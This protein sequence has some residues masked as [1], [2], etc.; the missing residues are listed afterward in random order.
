MTQRLWSIL[1]Q[2]GEAVPSE[3]AAPKKY[4]FSNSQTQTP[5]AGNASDTDENPDTDLADFTSDSDTEHEHSEQ[6]SA[7]SSPEYP[8]VPPAFEKD[9][10]T[11][12]TCLTE[13]QDAEDNQQEEE[14]SC[15]SLTGSDVYS[16]IFED[17]ED[18]ANRMDRRHTLSE[19]ADASSHQKTTI[20]GK[21]H[22]EKLPLNASDSKGHTNEQTTKQPTATSI[23]HLSSNLV[24]PNATRS[25]LS[26]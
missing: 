19:E 17:P 10:P 24:R 8:N 15:S 7:S 14:R 13:K 6:R 26:I 9:G 11:E 25:H 1:N 18:R 5:T 23:Q 3:E 22:S 16:L 21:Q 20:S 12:Q 2:T 4:A